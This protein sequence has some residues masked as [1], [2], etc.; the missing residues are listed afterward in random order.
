MKN[1]VLAITLAC[2]A[3]HAPWA[4][5]Q[6]PTWFAVVGEPGNPLLDTVEVDAA[7]AVA[8]ETMRLVKLRVNRAAPRTGFDGLEFR[9]YYATIMVDCAGMK[10]WH[11]TLSLFSE[12]LWHGQMRLL[13]YKESDGR[14]VAFADMSTNPRDRLIKAA[15]S[16]ALQ[17]R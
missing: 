15:C 11:R 4:A 1:L 10:A 13:E 7:S 17:S 6:S 16:V 2:A 3:V 8:F 14:S 5:A 12:P 9:S